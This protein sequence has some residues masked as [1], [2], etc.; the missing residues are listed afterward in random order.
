MM[1]ELRTILHPTGLHTG[2]R[3]AFRAALVLARRHG[4]RLVVLHVMRPWHRYG[5]GQMLPRYS[6]EK[7]ARGHALARYWGDDSNVSLE[8]RLG[9]GKPAEV[10][11]DHA[12]QIEADLIVM[13]QGRPKGLT[14]HFKRTVAEAVLRDA[15]CPVLIVGRAVGRTVSPASA[16][17]LDT[18]TRTPAGNQEPTPRELLE[19]Q[20]FDR[21]TPG[22]MSGKHLV[23]S[24]DAA[25]NPTLSL[26]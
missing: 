26:P 10:I 19:A 11:L 2:N 25:I 7:I 15:P 18:S 17:V 5:R 8:H 4:A 22:R 12:R 16:G 9:E 3:V 6:L 14:G 24:P 23:G 1:L 20:N 13:G 21:T